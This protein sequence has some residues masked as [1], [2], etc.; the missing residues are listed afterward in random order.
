MNCGNRGLLL[1]NFCGK[2]FGKKPRVLN[3]I[4]RQQYLILSLIFIVM[5]LTWQLSLM[6][7]YIRLSF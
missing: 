1:N 5:K 2:R 7:K 4:A 3:F 6:E